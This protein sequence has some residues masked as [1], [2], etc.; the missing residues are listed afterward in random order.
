VENTLA[1]FAAL[2]RAGVPS[3]MHVFERG[4]HGFGLGSPGEPL[5]AWPGL[6]LKWMAEESHAAKYLNR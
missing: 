6:L 2:R 5:S 1:M 4:G 3:E